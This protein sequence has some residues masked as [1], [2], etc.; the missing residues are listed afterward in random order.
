MNHW[1][2]THRFHG[3][4]GNSSDYRECHIKPDLLLLYWFEDNEFK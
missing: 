3:I 4:K 2:K 1:R